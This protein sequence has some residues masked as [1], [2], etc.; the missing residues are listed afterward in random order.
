MADKTAAVKPVCALL[1]NYSVEM[2]AKDGPHLEEA[3]DIIPQGTKI[4]VTFLPG[5]TLEMRIAAAKRARSGLSADPSHLGTSAEVARGTG[6]LPRPLAARSENRPC[7]RRC[8]RPSAANG[9]L[10][11]CAVDHPHRPPRKIRNPTDRHIGLSRGPSRY[12]QREI[13]AGQAGQAGR[14]PGTRP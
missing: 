12:R 5:D 10:R 6:R 7:F 3:A 9:S 1:N 2:T 13:V 11:G 8:G 14:H 4:P